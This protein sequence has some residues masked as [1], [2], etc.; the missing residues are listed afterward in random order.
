MEGSNSKGRYEGRRAVLMPR[1]STKKQGISV[2]DQIKQMRAFC[3]QHGITEVAIIGCAGISASKYW[4]RSDFK[5][6]RD[7]KRTQDDFDLLVIYDSYRFSRAGIIKGSNEICELEAEGIDILLSTEDILD[8]PDG[9]MQWA[10]RLAA[11]HAQARQISK[12]SCRGMQSSIESGRSLPCKRIPFGLEK[13]VRYPSGQIRHVI[14]GL[15]DGSQEVYDGVTGK[16][17]QS[18]PSIQNGMGSRYIKQ[19]EDLE[20]LRPGNEDDIAVVIQIFTRKFMDGWGARRI[21]KELNEKEVLSPK[22]GLWSPST[23]NH[24]LRNPA[25][26]GYVIGNQSSV[27]IYYQCSKNE[28]QKVV[29][30]AR[31]RT[32]K[33]APPQRIRPEKDWTIIEQPLMNDF[34]PGQFREVAREYIRRSKLM[35]AKHAGKYTHNRS[36]HTKSPYLLTGKLMEIRS[37]LRMKGHS[38]GKQR[39][40]RIAEADSHPGVVTP[41]PHQ[42]RSEGIDAVVTSAIHGVLTKSN[43]Y[44]DKICEEIDTQ[45]RAASISGVKA[46]QLRAE[47]KALDQDCRYIHRNRKEYGEDMT[48]SLI[49]E[50]RARCEEIDC[51]LADASRQDTIWGKDID[52]KVDELLAQ[53]VEVSGWVKDGPSASVK[54]LLQTLVSKATVNTKTKELQVE[55]RVP[56]SV[57]DNPQSLCLEPDSAFQVGYETNYEMSLPLTKLRFIYQDGKYSMIERIDPKPP[58]D[59]LPTPKNTGKKPNGQ[60]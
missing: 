49:E 29:K 26:V 46:D 18:F 33:Q 48:L 4:S 43:K 45:R 53:L 11:A 7:R 13:V 2:E 39:Y 59:T 56:K 41:K 52:K 51:K 54:R 50:N 14:R 19:K 17:V 20:D 44:R 35:S 10:Q 5:E 38:C 1:A 28:P 58:K 36:R 15:R 8:G 32:S 47:R 25:Y 42:I 40:Y 30:D 22:N 3:A 57:Y 12:T 27:A 55:F 31:H 34:L 24:I 21:A 23:V 37:G 16:L 9:E 60:Q 6:A